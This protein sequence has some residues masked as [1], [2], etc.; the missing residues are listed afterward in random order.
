MSVESAIGA[1]YG[2]AE[3]AIWPEFRA[4]LDR[5]ILETRA[6]MPCYWESASEW[7]ERGEKCID[8]KMP[9]CPSCA[10]RQ[11]LAE[12]ADVVVA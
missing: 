12:A 4:A 5:L 11:E 3:N 7:S 1:V 9:L 8:A 2:E 6:E 10:A